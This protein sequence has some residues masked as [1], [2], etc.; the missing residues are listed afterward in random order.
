MSVKRY[1]SNKTYISGRFQSSYIVPRER[2][3]DSSTTL[4]RVS[5]HRIYF[6]YM[7]KTLISIKT[8]QEIKKNVQRLAQEL[9]LSL[10]D[11]VN[12]ALR[13]FIRTREVYISSIPHMTLELERLLGIVEK[14]IKTGKNMSPAF[15]SA[16]KANKYLASL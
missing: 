3:E 15:S 9:G 4:D 5:Y 8:D 6:G 16:E 13:N 2:G 10:S 12:A 14:D 11:I 7:G 1:E